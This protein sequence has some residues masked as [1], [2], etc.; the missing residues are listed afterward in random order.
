LA[1]WSACNAIVGAAYAIFVLWRPLP[2][3]TSP[4]RR[5]ASAYPI[6][7]LFAY[8]AGI[9]A[10]YLIFAGSIHAPEFLAS[11]VV[12]LLIVNIRNA[13]DLMLSLLAPPRRGR[14]EGV[15]LRL[16]TAPSSPEN[17]RGPDDELR[18][19]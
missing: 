4:T 12:L 10:A 7:P 16:L 9:A 18:P 11:T 5:I 3:T 15:A 8:L 2:P 1:S 19:S 13:W 17:P 14:S 6:I